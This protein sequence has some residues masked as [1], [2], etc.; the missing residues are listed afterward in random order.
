MVGTISLFFVYG[1]FYIICAILANGRILFHDEN[2]TAAFVRT[3]F[4]LFPEVVTK[5]A[6][7]IHF[8]SHHISAWYIILH[9]IWYIILLQVQSQ[10]QTSTHVAECWCA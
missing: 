5:F 6:D 2:V 3:F 10:V 8:V 4:K 1:D 9:T 7:N